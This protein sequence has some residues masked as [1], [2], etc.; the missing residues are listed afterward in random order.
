MFQVIAVVAVAALVAVDQLTKSLF[1]A[2]VAEN[3]ATEFFFGLLRLTYVQNTGA[4]FSSFS[5]NTLVLT[6]FTLLLVA[7][8]FGYM[9]FNKKL[10]T[11]LRVCLIL[12]V[13]GGVG[14]LIDRIANGFVVDFIE[15]L[16]VNFAVFN[17]ADI[18]ITVGAFSLLIYEIVTMVRKEN[19]KQK[20]EEE[21][22]E[23]SDE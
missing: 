3:G 14:N 4:A 10:N 19:P 17:F 9:M 23:Q 8:C 6:V 13:A 7:G 12:I 2:Y 11:F 5:N 22:T 21:A 1:A 20:T 18:C 15:P 16:F